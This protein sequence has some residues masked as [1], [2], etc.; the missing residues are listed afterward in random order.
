VQC[1]CSSHESE[2]NRIL[3]FSNHTSMLES[4]PTTFSLPQDPLWPKAL[5]GGGEKLAKVP[6]ET[7]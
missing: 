7:G 3:S 2:V 6:R 5:G 4:D 1:C